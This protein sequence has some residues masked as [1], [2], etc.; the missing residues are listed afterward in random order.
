SYKHPSLNNIIQNEIMDEDRRLIN[1]TNVNNIRDLS[2]ECKASNLKKYCEVYIEKNKA[3]MDAIDT[4]QK[5]Q[6]HFI[7]FTN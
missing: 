2:D 1:E 6:T 4:A 7:E 3:I 5:K